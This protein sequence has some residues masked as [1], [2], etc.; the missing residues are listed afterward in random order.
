MYDATWQN[1]SFQ[2]G[3]YAILNTHWSQYSEQVN[4]KE[5]SV[6]VSALLQK[7]Y[8]RSAS[9]KPLGKRKANKPTVV[10]SVDLPKQCHYASVKKK[11]V[12]KANFNIKSYPEKEKG[13]K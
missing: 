10:I 13:K 4:G 12:K 6:T 1:P 9:S 5:V 3:M 2:Q 11:K 8:F 7:K